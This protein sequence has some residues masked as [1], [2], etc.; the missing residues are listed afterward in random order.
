MK[1]KAIPYH[2]WIEWSDEDSIFIGYCPD[3]FFGGVCHGKDEAKLYPR[4]VAIIREEMDDL[5]A[6]GKALPPVSVRPMREL[7]AA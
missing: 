1:S 5:K 2:H 7:A 6:E 4:L 3:L